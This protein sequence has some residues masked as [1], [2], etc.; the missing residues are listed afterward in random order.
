MSPG[1]ATH[2][3]AAVSPHMSHSVGGLAGHVHFFLHE[4]DHGHQCELV[5]RC[6]HHADHVHIHGHIECR[7]VISKAEYILSREGLS[8]LPVPLHSH[9]H[10]AV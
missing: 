1:H 6:M 2:H 4:V 8:S 7:N 10:E 3:H 5:G 9:G